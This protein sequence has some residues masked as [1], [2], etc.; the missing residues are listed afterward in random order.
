MRLSTLR[1]LGVTGVLVGAQLVIAASLLE[2]ALRCVKF[3]RFLAWLR[4]AARGPGAG[5]PAGKHRLGLPRTLQLAA[6]AARVWRGADCCLP[7]SL[8][9]LWLL[10]ADQREACVVLGVRKGPA[11]PFR[12][13]A[14]V[15]VSPPVPGIVDRGAGFTV[16]GRF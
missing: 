16:L 2:L 13:H 3:P 4:A 11:E 6:A 1:R 5:F 9:T 12:A 15:E 10:L 8:L 14:W 7:R